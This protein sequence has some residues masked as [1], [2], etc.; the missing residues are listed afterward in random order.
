MPYFLALL[1]GTL[2]AGMGFALGAAIA[3]ALAPALGISGFE[4]ASG[5]F[6]VFMGGPIG[7]LVGLVLGPVLV[8]RRHGHRGVGPVAARVALVAAGVAA[9]AA[10]GLAAFW[11]MRPVLNANGPPPQ[12]VFEI[13]LPPGVAPGAADGVR[14]ELQTSRNRMPGNLDGLREEAGRAVVA[15]RVDMYYRAWRRTLVLTMP[16]K[17]DVLFDLRL[18]LSPAHTRTFGGWQPADHIAEPGTQQVRRA[19]ATDRY[20]IRYRTEWAGED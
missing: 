9:I 12:L 5:Y 4:G 17:T 13:R 8:F 20:E 16:D 1:A 19:A 6:A 14:T 15:G 18:G 10:A 11:V 7:A 3:A 2:G